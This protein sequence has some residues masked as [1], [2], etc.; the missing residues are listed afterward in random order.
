MAS[1]D[2][3]HTAQ[4][5][6]DR[7]GMRAYNERLILSVIRQRGALSKAELARVTGLS[8]QAVSMIVN[9][10]LR[11]RLVR[12]QNKVRGQVGQPHTPIAL[13]PRGSFSLGLKIGRRN[14]ETVLIDFVGGVVA[15][16]RVEY[17]SPHY[18]WV[19]QSARA[20]LNATLNALTPQEHARIAGLGVAMP[21][22]LH[23]WP[24]ELGLDPGALD[25]WRDTDAAG[26]LG[27]AVG[28]QACAYNDAT[29]ACAAE[30]YFGAAITAQS[31]LY[32]FVG[33]FIGGGVVL[34]GRLHTGR[35]G[36]AG[37][38]GSMPMPQVDGAGRAEQ[39]I[40]RASL[41]FLQRRL[42][43]AGMDASA[44]I[45][46]DT[47]DPQAEA[48]FE[49]WCEEAAAAIARA[50]VCGASVIDFEEAVIDGVMRADWRDRLVQAVRSRLGDFNQSGLSPITVTAGSI[51][52][53]AP[54]LGAALLPMTLKYAPHAE[55][56]V[57]SAPPANGRPAATGAS[58]ER[59]AQ[60]T[61]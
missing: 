60:G 10:L 19:M 48:L 53:P 24:T 43:A 47:D 41:I 33:D 40:H 30:M 12:K 9:A 23:A 25:E 22:D 58:G 38:L 8:A 56:L 5:G 46:G 57:K 42:T 28:L 18:A 52:A 37:A 44:L 45:A 39:L 4:R 36:N 29:A 16:R 55:L 15:Q 2:E 21:G 14:L 20:A 1:D 51:G 26:E 11:E 27:A 49:P 13:N 50:V 59:P 61:A 54:A 6:G 31:A 3:L 35:R 32:L 7:S 34:D 17:A